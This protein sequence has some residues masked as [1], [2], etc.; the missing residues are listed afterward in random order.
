MLILL[1]DT[2]LTLKIVRMVK[3][4]NLYSTSHCHLCELANDILLRMQDLAEVN[5][6]EIAYDD[7]LVVTYGSRIP[8]LQ[9]PD[10]KTEL[11]WPFSSADIVEFLN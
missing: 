6:I 9:R 8:V 11:N 1:F 5:I 10:T 4:V 7:L 3:Q 2:K